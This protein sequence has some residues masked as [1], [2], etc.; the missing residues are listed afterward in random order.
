MIHI[1]FVFLKLLTMIIG[2]LVAYAAFRAYRRYQSR[3]LAYVAIG[4][5]FISL[6]EGFEGL[7]FD[8]TTL[9]LYQASIVHSVLMVIG[10][11]LI[12]YSIY[13]GS[14]T[15]VRTV[16]NSDNSQSPKDND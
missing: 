6:G 8:F 2:L 3:P 7:L 1:E 4:F 16:T 10:M 15:A 13:S 12:L 11:G 14:N 5:V 9:T